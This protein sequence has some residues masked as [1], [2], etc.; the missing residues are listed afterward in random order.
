[1]TLNPECTAEIRDEYNRLVVFIRSIERALAA[2]DYPA[3]QAAIYAHRNI[4]NSG[5]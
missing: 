5:V 2:L 1:M 3:P 4:R